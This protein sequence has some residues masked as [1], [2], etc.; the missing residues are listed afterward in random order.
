MLI[1]LARSIVYTPPNKPGVVN[2]KK[3]MGEEPFFKKCAEVDASIKQA[4][5]EQPDYDAL[6]SQ[7]IL[8]GDKHEK[9]AESCHIRVGIPVKPMLAKPTKGVN[10]VLQRFEG[11]KFT[12]EYKYDGFRG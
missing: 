2:Q 10:V 11:I 5:C 9:L 4:I 7:L 8:I 3:K 6:V 12:C 1:A